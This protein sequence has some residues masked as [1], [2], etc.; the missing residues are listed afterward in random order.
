[1]KRTK[2]T[3]FG[4]T[5]IEIILYLGIMMVIVGSVSAFSALLLSARAKAHTIL[6]VEQQGTAI[7]QLMSATI[8]GSDGINAPQA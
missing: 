4:F 3:Q 1:M 7:L 5:L 6:E 2:Q 8:R